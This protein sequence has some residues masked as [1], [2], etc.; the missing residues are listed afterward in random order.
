MNFPSSVSTL[1]TVVSDV[2]DEVIVRHEAGEALGAIGSMEAYDA[3]KEA[4]KDEHIEIRETAALALSLLEWKA[5]NGP[6]AVAAL[7]ENPYLSHDP[8]PAEVKTK[9]IE[10][11]REQLLDASLPMFDRYRAMFSL[12]N[13][14]TRAAVK[15]SSCRP[16]YAQLILLNQHRYTISTR[17]FL[18]GR[19]T[20]VLAAFKSAL[21][22]QAASLSATCA[23]SPA[24]EHVLHSRVI[25]ATSGR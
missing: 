14:G 13:R 15:V 18:T 9:T 3:L 11:L 7:D 19:A 17:S 5:A 4:S 25:A 22:E 1:V 20:N 10:Q 6:D 12:R 23:A 21:L 8:A 16:S 24:L 2:T